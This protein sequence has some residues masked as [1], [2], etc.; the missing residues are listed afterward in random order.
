MPLH[1]N[2]TQF[3]SLIALISLLFNTVD[4][5]TKTAEALHGERLFLEN[6]FAESYY[7][8]IKRGGDY[9]QP[10]DVGDPQLNRTYR[11]FGLPP[12][13]IP[14]ATSPFK[15]SSYSCRTCHMVDEHND[16]NELGMRAFADFASRS[17]L[18]K[19]HDK[20]FVTTRN[21]PILVSYP[22]KIHNILFHY[23]GEF[24][25]LQ[26]LITGTLTG[27]NF[28]W[29]PNERKI[30][31]D[32]ICSVIKADHGTNSLAKKYGGYSYQEIFQG[33]TTDDISLPE[34]KLIKRE[35]YIDVKKASCDQILFSIA[36]LLEEYINHL[37]FSNY[38]EAISPYDKFLQIND[39]PRTPNKNESDQEYSLRLISLIDTLE[40][41]NNLK[42]IS[43]NDATEN[44]E[45][46]YHDQLYKFEASELQGLKIFFNQSNEND[47][48][49]GNCVACHPAPHFTDF[50]YHNIGVTQA[51]YETVH[52][53]H[54]FSDLP[55]PNLSARKQLA[56]TYLPAT[57][58]H[59]DRLG[60]FRR[61]AN[62]QNTSHTDLGA[63]NI[64]FNED[65]PKPQEKLL[66][67]FCD[68]DNQCANKDIALYRSIAAFKTP[69]IRNLGHS[70]PYMHNGQIVDLH[71]VL[72]F[73]FT[74][75]QRSNAGQIRNPDEELM[76]ID[77][78][79]SEINPLAD[80]LISLY[81]DFN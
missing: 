68:N 69:S 6:R 52:G 76:K 22:A 26:E 43:K 18:P 29:L 57:S 31:E 37:N 61:K 70:A 15:G 1:L 14:F 47:F 5:N 56:E 58:A 25:S 48:G 13:Q 80:F 50:K 8:F 35:F 60:V 24:S 59:P 3:F 81:E 33:K 74:A 20:Q 21:S 4:A 17:P 65:Y 10:I 2:T 23:D 54:S 64:L 32:H 66:R 55:I 49:T 38:G 36:Y 67:M 79:S 73:Y 28:G 71:N 77:F 78:K 63:W 9:N 40:N 34:E 7:Q 72:G 39:L 16:Q 12:Y 41:D 46:L 45:F 53:M 62:K 51:E 75:S 19:R 27:R 44:G 42:F 30:A 11:F